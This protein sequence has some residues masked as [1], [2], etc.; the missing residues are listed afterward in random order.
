MRFFL[1][2]SRKYLILR[3]ARRARLEG[4][5]MFVQAPFADSFTSSFRGGDEYHV[6]I[7]QA[8]VSQTLRFSG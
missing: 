3:S 1:M 8:I 2:P 5:N 6:D 4:R 7:A